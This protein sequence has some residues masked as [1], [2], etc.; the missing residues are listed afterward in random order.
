MCNLARWRTWCTVLVHTHC[1]DGVERVLNGQQQH[2]VSTVGV[3]CVCGTRDA[4]AGRVVEIGLLPRN[5]DGLPGATAYAAVS[6]LNILKL[7][8]S[9]PLKRHHH[10][11]AARTEMGEEIV[12]F[13]TYH[14]CLNP[15][16]SVLNLM[17]YKMHQL[18]HIYSRTKINICPDGFWWCCTDVINDRSQHSLSWWKLISVLLCAPSTQESEHCFAWHTNHF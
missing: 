17:R 14:C 10:H 3:V 2:F 8:Q 6:A 7:H 1:S 13:I 12:F 16:L 9:L 15:T 4:L 11:I 18:D 5:V